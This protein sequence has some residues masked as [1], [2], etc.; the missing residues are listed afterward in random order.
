MKTRMNFVAL[1]AAWPAAIGALVLC[2]MLV[3]AV[4]PWQLRA[5]EPAERTAL[6]LVQDEQVT[7]SFRVANANGELLV[8][9][10]QPGLSFAMLGGELVVEDAAGE[11]QIRVTTAPR[12]SLLVRQGDLM[13]ACGSFVELKLKDQ[14]LARIQATSGAT[15]SALAA[16]QGATGAELG[17]EVVTESS[18]EVTV[19]EAATKALRVLGPEKPITP[20]TSPKRDDVPPKVQIKD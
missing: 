9:I 16:L 11:P 5:Q 7:G 3:R 1:V 4:D 12:N 2:L 15:T 6:T 17:E 10:Y 19:E 18:P 8:S 13:I 14:L 20:T